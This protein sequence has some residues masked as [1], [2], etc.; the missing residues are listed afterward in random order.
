VTSYGPDEITVGQT[1]LIDGSGPDTNLKT[2][3]SKAASSSARQEQGR[4][5]HNWG[6]V[7]GQSKAESS[8]VTLFSPQ[9]CS[10]RKI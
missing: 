1:L 4:C 3:V 6:E 10:D 8:G 2:V 9:S 5:I 7:S